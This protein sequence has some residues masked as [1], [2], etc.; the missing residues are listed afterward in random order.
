MDTGCDCDTACVAA[1][2]NWVAAQASVAAKQYD[3]CVLTRYCTDNDGGNISGPFC[4]ALVGAQAMLMN[5]QQQ[6]QSA[7]AA[8]Q[9][10]C[11]D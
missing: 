1:R 5:R 9:S 11:A 3:V 4:S 10:A 6:A 2:K 8:V 7:M